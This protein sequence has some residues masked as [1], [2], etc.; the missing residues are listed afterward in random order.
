MNVRGELKIFSGTANAPLAE[1]IAR[2]LGCGL[3]K[4]RI[5]RF[6]DGEVYVKFDESVRGA[7]V[8]II[9][10]TCP[11]VDAHL[12]ELLVALDALKRASAGRI[13][14]VIPYYGYARQEKKDRP[15]EPITAK[16]IADL[17]KTAGAG[18][19][20][21]MDLHA[22]AIQG[23]FDIPV[24]HLTATSLLTNYIKE[25]GLS[26]MV[27][28]SPDEGRVKKARE[29][30]N[31]LGAPLAVGYKY[32][33]APNVAEVTHIAGNVKGKTP[34]IIEDMIATGSSILECVKMLLE[35]GAKPEIYV[36][37]THGLFTGKAKEYLERPEIKE[38]VVTD[39]VPITKGRKLSNVKVLSVAGLFGEAIRRLRENKSI[40]SLFD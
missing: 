33:P 7:D 32:H 19:V 17:L 10:P 9:Q 5:E 36:T 28:V 38:I 2:Y 18:R 15:R 24:D 21:T 40:S 14:A 37:C 1:G 29:V 25:K 6:S 4:L 11:P 39:T 22:E 31:R 30:T 16:L 26:N 27:I 12:V 3:G 13:T 23:F 35:H 34:I 8:F 20:I